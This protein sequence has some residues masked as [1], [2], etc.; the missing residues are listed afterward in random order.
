MNAFEAT[1]EKY[2]Q[3]GW[4]KFVV[5]TDNNAFFIDSGDVPFMQNDVFYNNYSIPEVNWS[6]GSLYWLA[7]NN[8]VTQKTFDK[9]LNAIIDRER[10]KQEEKDSAAFSKTDRDHRIELLHD[11]V[12]YMDEEKGVTL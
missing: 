10:K 1:V 6:W 4:M 3:D 7:S 12:K 11:F 5:K 2:K 9:I 8:I